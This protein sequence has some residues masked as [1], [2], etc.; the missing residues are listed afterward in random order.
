MGLILVVGSLCSTV[1]YRKQW[2]C[3]HGTAKP[4]G[5]LPALYRTV[6]C[7]PG[8]QCVLRLHGKGDVPYTDYVPARTVVTITFYP[9]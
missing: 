1:K 4:R 7:L 5:S 6:R 8:Q 9:K 2:H 3:Q